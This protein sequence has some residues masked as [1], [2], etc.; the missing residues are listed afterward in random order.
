MKAI[1]KLLQDCKL[2][3]QTAYLLILIKTENE[4]GHETENETDTECLLHNLTQTGALQL[5]LQP[6]FFS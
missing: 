4:T 3:N 2:L 1:C 5:L 6:E